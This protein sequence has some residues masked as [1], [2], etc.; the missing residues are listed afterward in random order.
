MIYKY[1]IFNEEFEKLF[2]IKYI[3]FLFE[4]GVVNVFNIIYDYVILE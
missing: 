4:I 1:K 3:F 2:E